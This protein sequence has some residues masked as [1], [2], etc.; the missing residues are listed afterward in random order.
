MEAEAA[1][2]EN[3][4]LE[5]QQEEEEGR[6]GDMHEEVHIKDDP[7][8]RRQATVEEAMEELEVGGRDGRREKQ[9]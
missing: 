4:P 5:Q 1:D 2:E 9:I 3:L 7:E 8:A 6:G